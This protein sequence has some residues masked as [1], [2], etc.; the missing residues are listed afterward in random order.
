[1][2]TTLPYKCA[3]VDD[4]ALALDLI[5]RHV[6]AI[7][8]LELAARFNNAT[9]AVDILNTLELDVLFLD[10]EMPGIN[11]IDVIKSLQHPP[12]IVLTTAYSEYAVEAFELD[13]F[14]YIVKPITASRFEKT[15][16]K[17]KAH[18]EETQR[19]AAAK[20]NSDELFIKVDRSW[21]KVKLSDILYIQGLQKYLKIVAKDGKWV[22]LMTMTS[23]REQLAHLRFFQIHKSFLINLHCL[24]KIEGNR[25]YLGPHELPIAK[26]NKTALLQALKI[27]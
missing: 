18:F 22:T 24:D 16:N 13:V 23:M 9:E 11:G 19:G 5:E 14:D 15:A 4:E 1:M 3:A 10:V 8:E 25:A 2:S 20:I 6:Q 26:A 7:P 12:L 17:I 27:E 21:V